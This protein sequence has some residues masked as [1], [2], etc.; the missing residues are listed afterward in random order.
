MKKSA[1]TRHL[2]L[3]SALCL[4]ALSAQAQSTVTAYGLLDLSVG[5]TKAP[6]GTSTTAVD[7][8]KMTTSFIGFGGSEDLGGGLSA[9]FK[10]EGFLRVDTGDQGRFTGDTTWARTAS[11]GL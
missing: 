9:V 4:T 2:T 6:G 11:V 3:V 5:S 8:G 7:S 10:M 1:L